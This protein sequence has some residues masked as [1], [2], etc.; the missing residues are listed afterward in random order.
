MIN[1]TVKFFIVAVFML[2]PCISFALPGAHDPVK[3]GQSYSCESCHIPGAG[4][5]IGNTDIKYDANVC[6]VCHISGNVK[7][8]KHFSKFDFAN[9]Y[10]NAG[11][12]TQV[13]P[14]QNSHKW[15]GPDTVPGAGAQAPTD[16][17]LLRT[18]GG[19]YFPANLSCNRCH[20]VH[21]TSTVSG[22]GF[23]ANPPYLRMEMTSDQLCRDCH[24][25]RDT[26]DHKVGTHPIGVSYTSARNA[27][28]LAGSTTKTTY[29]WLPVTNIT[30][31]TGQVKLV[32]GTVVCST[33]HGVH[34]T[35]SRTSTFDPYSST[36]TYGQLS[37]SKGY[38]L[39]V[40]AY[41]KTASDI[42]ICSNCHVSK[43][44][45]LGSRLGKSPVQCNDCHS[46]HVEYD[47]A[48]VPLS[49][50]AT[51]NVN[52]V[53]RYL[54][55]TTA[56]RVSKRILYRSDTT[57]EYW[58]STKTGVCQ[59]C[60]TPPQNHYA[61]TSQY[62]N[63]TF[64]AAGGYAGCAGCHNHAEP[65][66]AFSYGLG[67]SCSNSCHGLPPTTVVEGGTTGRVIGYTRFSEAN[68]PHAAHATGGGANVNDFDCNECHQGYTMPKDD[69][70][71]VVEVFVTPRTL[72][73][74]TATYTKATYECSN[75]YCH[76][77]G[78]GTWK[79]PSISWA[80]PKGTIIGRPDEC[81]QCH[82]D[83]NS[84]A[85]HT[86]HL[87]FGY[88]CI[89]CHA[90]TVFN[91][92]TLLE[93]AKVVNGT[94]T[95]KVK[96]VAYSGVAPAVGSSCAT[97]ACHSNGFGAAPNITPTWGTPASGA[98]GACHWTK[99]TSTV[100]ST[101]SHSQHFAMTAEFPG[102]EQEVCVKCH[103]TYTSET[104]ATHVNGVM[105]TGGTGCGICH[106]SPYSTVASTP[107][108][109]TVSTGCGQ[110]HTLVGAFTGLGTS[111]N[112]GSHTKHMRISLATCNQCHAGAIAGV[113]G[114]NT[115]A[116]AN[117][118]VTN[119]GYPPV[120]VKHTAGSGYATCTSAGAVG[121]HV[122]PYATTALTTPTWGVAGGCASCHTGVGAF[123]GSNTS[124]TTG[125]H[126]K[127]IAKSPL[128]AN[129]HAGAVAGSSGGNFHIDGNVDVTVVG[130]AANVTKHTQGSGYST[131]SN[132]GAAACHASPYSTTAPVVAP[133]WG[134]AAGCASCHTLVGAFT[135]SGTSPT[136][137]THTKHIAISITC[138][139]CHAGAVAGISG[140]NFHSDGNIDVIGGYTANVTKH[141]S[142]TYT[143]T[144]STSTCHGSYSP[145]WGINSSFDYC[146]RCH[147]TG[148]ATINSTN[149]DLVA[150]NLNAGTD[151][152]QVSTTNSK[153]GAHR[154]HLLN[155]NGFS[156]YSTID[157]R[158]ESCHGTLPSSGTYTHADSTSS[159]IGKYKT[160]ANRWGAMTGQTYVGTTCANTY[161]HNPAGTN[162]TLNTA[163]TGT[164][165]A[166][167][168]TNAAYI[169]DG[170]KKT[171]ANCN[172]CH[173]VP[174]RAGFG[175][176]AHAGATSDT[177]VATQ[178]CNGCH[179]HNGDS[180]GTVVG[181]RHMDGIK[182]GGGGDCK[183]CH[184]YPPLSA[185]EFDARGAGFV[186]AALNNNGNGANASHHLVHLSPSLTIASGKTPCLPCHPDVD[187]SGVHGE[188]GS[189]VV[190]SSVQVNT[191]TTD[192]T[193]THNSNRSKRYNPTTRTCS[194]ISC[195]FQPTTAW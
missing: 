84:S 169:A 124:P 120:V 49:P 41:G 165:I 79:S 47:A 145:T 167:S 195:H 105:N 128:C 100:L 55:Y 14:D 174:G 168:W 186:D 117:V 182:Q 141:T 149:R 9:I 30:N 136:T 147:G 172:Q 28:I 51:P 75:V 161:C 151:A 36:H 67:G 58:N 1:Q 12:Q 59:A 109:G 164:G 71:S 18:A 122:N 146:T 142:G 83:P 19:A 156:N 153:T 135:G 98:C 77:N 17:N 126:T 15:F 189:T 154:T 152:G 180:T 184:G 26:Q 2:M 159:P 70:N 72:P 3:G 6:L 181:K 52:L 157:Y 56:G 91:N 35:D 50:E 104:N 33:C 119:V 102:T 29:R 192:F 80:S 10:D 176:F 31:P 39:R 115:H 43:N 96:E 160:L 178:L 138:V 185:A 21:G 101:G 64:V 150:P 118:D 143:G 92:T 113:S 173:K 78:N 16:T 22:S 4:K 194:N 89:T 76:S 68:T 87:A 25:S 116:N 42:N 107:A 46:G 177:Y 130:Y 127:H 95:N 57:K 32:N 81:Q 86:K 53:R 65:T 54:Q 139:N 23:A 137:G 121:C 129:C 103:T 133:T 111:P 193:F 45:N 94:H 175:G 27:N 85:A 148:N 191:V 108:W 61:T 183:G 93:S 66:G 38:L 155:L 73:G 60:H 134:S 74:L 140:G 110:C 48:A 144:C 13:N 179:G 131:C 125:G 112:T 171:A 7:T 44:H 40:D 188:G 114:G 187:T 11:I 90:A 99:T 34:N 158:C 163:N 37:S 88:G 24:R 5:N 166:P 106:S 82:D 162:G 132:A 63:G 62:P 20:S 97:I 123:T 170:T 8:K 69:P 190:R